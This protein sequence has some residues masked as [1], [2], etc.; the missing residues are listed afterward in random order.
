M[1]IPRT[2]LWVILLLFVLLPTIEQWVFADGTAWYRPYIIWALLI[3]VVLVSQHLR[4]KAKN[5]R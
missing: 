5:L 1:Y 4:N 3:I 2:T